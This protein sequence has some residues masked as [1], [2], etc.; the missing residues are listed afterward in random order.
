MVLRE[1]SIP[2]YPQCNNADYL[3]LAI[4][5]IVQILEER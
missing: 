4:W 1:R 3:N 5:D 2:P